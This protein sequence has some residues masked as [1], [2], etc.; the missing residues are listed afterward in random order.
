MIGKQTRQERDW[1]GILRTPGETPA[2]RG[3]AVTFESSSP[4]AFPV[5]DRTPEDRLLED[6]L[7]LEARAT[8]Y[9][10]LEAAAQAVEALGL[11]K[12][13]I[14]VD[15]RAR[16]VT[17]CLFLAGKRPEDDAWPAL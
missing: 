14:P 9:E 3:S 6:V 2:R 1:Y 13:R 7:A 5:D 15:M 10:D 12:D 8:Q 11:M 4:R 16:A 17:T